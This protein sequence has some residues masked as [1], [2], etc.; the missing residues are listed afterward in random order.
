MGH[1]LE[2]YSFT[3]TFSNLLLIEGH[4]DTVFVR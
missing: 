4:F 2:G 1:R 3:K